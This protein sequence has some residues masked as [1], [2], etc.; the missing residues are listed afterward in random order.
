M[1]G[2]RCSSWSAS[3]AVAPSSVTV[4]QYTA[5]FENVCLCADSVEK[6]EPLEGAAKS[7]KGPSAGCTAVVALVR[8]LV[9]FCICPA[10]CLLFCQL[11]LHLL[12]VHCSAVNC[13]FSCWPMLIARGC[14][15]GSCVMLLLTYVA[16]ALAVCYSLVQ[17]CCCQ[18]QFEYSCHFTNCSVLLSDT[19]FWAIVR[20]L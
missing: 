6:A 15:C 10:L 14:C 2:P 16:A 8:P 5:S 1:H 3:L 19:C 18:L 11:L 4:A 17:A 20:C 9:L 12:L 7:Y 13:C